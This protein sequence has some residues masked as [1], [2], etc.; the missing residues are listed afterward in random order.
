MQENNYIVELVNIHKSYGL[1]DVLKDVNLKVK[2]GDFILIRGKSGVGKSTLIKI[3]SL[4]QTP[5]SGIVKL[6]GRDVTKLNDNQ[7][8]ELR[9]KNIGVVFQF[10]NL[11]PSLTVQ[12]NIELPL[13]LAA[14]KSNQ[15]KQRIAELLTYFQLEHLADRFPENLSGGEKQR[16]AI[17][18]A[19]ANNP[20]IIIADEPMSSIDD[21]NTAL[22][23]NLLISINKNQK[24][25]II[26]TTTDLYE[27]LPTTKDC[28][29]KDS[30]LEQI[31]EKMA[32]QNIIK[33]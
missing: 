24:V 32:P 18:R 3:L 5:D 16:I 15:R 25:T 13:A 20:K 10:F 1:T 4:L 11:L 31:N 30:Q 28:L 21:E 26:M 6:F 14:V 12:E 23:M 19:L 7:L 33:L 27:K 17:I 9:L 8:S 2:Q 22:L 29:L